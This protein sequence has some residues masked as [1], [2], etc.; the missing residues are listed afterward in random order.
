MLEKNKHLLNQERQL[1]E[2]VVF[3]QEAL[4]KEIK[5]KQNLKI[6]YSNFL[7]S[8]QIKENEMLKIIGE[9]KGHISTLKREVENLRI[10]NS[11]LQ[12]GLTNEG[13]T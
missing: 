12:E 4:A 1:R 10:R 2:Q 11:E 3:E 8:N 5:E 13:K 7:E 6:E 9:A